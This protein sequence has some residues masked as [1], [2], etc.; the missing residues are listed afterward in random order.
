MDRPNGLQFREFAP[1]IYDFHV[2]QQVVC[3]NDTFKHVSVD[4]LIRKGEISTLRWVG[5]Y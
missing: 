5:E 1:M 2:G 3:L 4:Q